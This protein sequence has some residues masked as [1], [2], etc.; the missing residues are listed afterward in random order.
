MDNPP[1]VEPKIGSTRWSLSLSDLHSVL[2]KLSD[3]KKLKKLVTVPE[4]SHSFFELRHLAEILFR[5][6]SEKK[7]LQSWI[8]ISSSHCL[9]VIAHP[10]QASQCHN[11]LGDKKIQIKQVHARKV[12]EINLY[13]KLLGLSARDGYGRLHLRFHRSN[14][15]LG[16]F[17]VELNTHY[18]K[19]PVNCNVI[20]M[21]QCAMSLEYIIY[22]GMASIIQISAGNSF[23]HPTLHM[24]RRH[25]KRRK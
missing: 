6:I 16:A 20:Q 10:P 9:H 12:S 14:L 21:N 2:Q 4:R 25:K 17:L 5:F 8:D 11:I 18:T 7:I 23:F 13:L 1:I 22:H 19:L 24:V 15:L 3:V